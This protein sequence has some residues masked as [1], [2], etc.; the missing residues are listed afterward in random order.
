MYM[1]TCQIMSVSF[2][3][4]MLQSPAFRKKGIFVEF[5]L[6]VSQNWSHFHRGT[7]DVLWEPLGQRKGCKGLHVPWGEPWRFSFSPKSAVPNCPEI[8]DPQTLGFGQSLSPKSEVEKS[9]FNMAELCRWAT[10]AYGD[11]DAKTISLTP[12]V[13]RHLWRQ[14][15]TVTSKNISSYR[16]NFWGTFEV[17][18]LNIDVIFNSKIYITSILFI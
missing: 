15:K 9:C 12:A 5:D 13:T 18:I 2:V 3:E 1:S 8:L 10:I 6:F 16:A 7:G 17:C 14:T 4:R 11:E